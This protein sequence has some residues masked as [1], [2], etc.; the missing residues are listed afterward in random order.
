M[1]NILVQPRSM[2]TGPAVCLAVA[3]VLAEE[4]EA[5]VAMYPTDHFI[6]PEEKF[7]EHI[8]RLLVPSGAPPDLK[9][10]LFGVKP[11]GAQEG[12]SWIVPGRPVAARG[13]PPL[14]RVDR[15]MERATPGLGRKLSKTGAFLNTFIMAGRARTFLYL[16]W[17]RLPRAAKQI[18]RFCC[19]YWSGADPR[20]AAGTF[21]DLD[22]FD[23]SRVVLQRMEE[24]LLFS[25]LNEIHWKDWDTLDGFCETIEAM[26]WTDRAGEKDSPHEGAGAIHVPS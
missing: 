25:P 13:K 26:G 12:M 9:I 10:V 7:E 8:R 22:A 17:N 21:E 19:E 24:H 20:K 15:F 6:Y 23:F 11:S 14:F 18:Q 16:I 1:K 4:P 2:G 5:S 3:R